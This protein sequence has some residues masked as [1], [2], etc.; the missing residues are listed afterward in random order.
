MPVAL[1]LFSNCKCVR[2]SGY[3]SERLGYITTVSGPFLVH[4]TGIVTTLLLAFRT[5]FSYEKKCE[6]P[7]AV[8]QRNIAKKKGELRPI[9]K[10]RLLRSFSL[11]DSGK[12]EMCYFKGPGGFGA[13]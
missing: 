10:F 13:S 12:Y 1:D 6:K 8:C 2:S 11:L 4:R 3:L 5:F 9:F 7:R